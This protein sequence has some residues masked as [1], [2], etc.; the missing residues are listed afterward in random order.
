MPRRA[1]LALF[2]LTIAAPL[3]AQ[4][5]TVARIEITPA[6]VDV[7]I[8]DTVQL[9]AVAY[10][11][12]GD[13]VQV[14]VQWLT[15]YEVGRIDS[16]GAFVGLAIGERVIIANAGGATATV[17]VTVRPLP[18]SRIELALPAT[19]V[20]ATSWLPLEAR[21]YDAA[22][23]LAFEADVEWSSS[24]PSVAEVVGPYLA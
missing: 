4:E 21:P 1:V 18:P 22:G 16:T 5:P 17:P 2:L 19:T 12:S 23:R 3:A 9:A 7:A 11:A 15:S 20:A 6:S 24:D 10:D 13:A 14:P 8:G